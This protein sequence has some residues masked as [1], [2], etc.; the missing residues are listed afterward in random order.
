M[1]LK[2]DM[3]LNAVFAQARN[4]KKL[5]SVEIDRLEQYVES[6]GFDLNALKNGELQVCD[7]FCVGTA[8]LID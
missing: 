8:C 7:A 6:Q 5:W 1:N 4:D 2:K 3:D